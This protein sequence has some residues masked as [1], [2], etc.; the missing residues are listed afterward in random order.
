ME[1]QAEGFEPSGVG[2]L[3]T[4]STV[5]RLSPVGIPCGPVS[6]ASLVPV[7]MLSAI[8][9]QSL[10]SPTWEGLALNRFRQKSKKF[11]PF[12]VC[13]MEQPATTGQ[14]LWIFRT[15]PQLLLIV[16]RSPKRSWRMKSLPSCRLSI[17]T[18]DISTA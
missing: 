4:C 12:V 1:V 16:A 11:I 3:P 9:N 17:L 8:S 18:R 14:V 2:K 6:Q 15:L 13:I 7:F 5:I 10:M